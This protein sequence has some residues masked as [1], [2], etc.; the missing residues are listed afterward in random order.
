MVFF[1]TVVPA[2]FRSLTRGA[3]L[4]D[5]DKLYRRPQQPQHRV[6]GKRPFVPIHKLW[7][8]SYQQF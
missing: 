6:V 8:G 7:Y 3:L 5:S 2:L 1:E 4:P